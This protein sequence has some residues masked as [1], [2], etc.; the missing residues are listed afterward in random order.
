ML[1]AITFLRPGNEPSLGN[2]KGSQDPARF[3]SRL[4]MQ[5]AFMKNTSHSFRVHLFD[6]LLLDPRNRP[7]GM[8]KGVLW[9]VFVS[10]KNHV[11]K[12]CPQ[13]GGVPKQGFV[14]MIRSWW[15]SSYDYS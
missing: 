8:G 14:E 15:Q 12:F 2:V 11:L 13:D 5:F 7:A 10:P 4:W 9:F 3:F 6:G 1:I